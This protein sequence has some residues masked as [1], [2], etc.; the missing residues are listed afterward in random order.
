MKSGKIQLKKL[1]RL[2]T[3]KDFTEIANKI[4]SNH[5]DTKNKKDID[6]LINFF[7]DYFKKSNPRFNEIRF[8]EYIE[9]GIYGN[10]V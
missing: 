2:L 3:R 8:R 7:I 6:F 1:K 4:I 9:V 10:T 5:K